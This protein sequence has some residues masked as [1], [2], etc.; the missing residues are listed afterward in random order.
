M[1]ALVAGV[2][3]GLAGLLVFL[4]VHHFWITPIWFI[5]PLGLVIA[6]IGGAVVGWAYT[7]LLP[8]LPPRPWTTFAMAALIVVILLP[9]LILAE[10]RR[11]LFTITGSEAVLSA[12]MG[13]A[14]TIFVLE[15]LVTAASVGG[16]VGLVIGHT[17]QAALATA[18]AGF[19]F[20]LGPGHNI[21]LIGG[22]PGVGKEVLIMM[23]IILVSAQVLVETHYLL[24]GT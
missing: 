7:E 1:P 3:S 5:L 9:A 2:L 10:L 19:A 11:P 18:L 14:A 24:T 15:L 22:T 13:K 12:T 6:A 23:A 20:A 21:P 17:W 8:G 4:L 16:I